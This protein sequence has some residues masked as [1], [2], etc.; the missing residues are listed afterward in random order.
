MLKKESLTYKQIFKHS[1]V[2]DFS[3]CCKFCG[4]N[5]IK[6]VITSFQLPNRVFFLFYVLYFKENVS[7]NFEY[8]T[9]QKA[10]KLSVLRPDLSFLLQKA[11][12]SYLDNRCR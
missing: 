5:Q 12:L 7:R 3:S 9:S 10:K 11:R 4:E 1:V 2:S 6:R 8:L